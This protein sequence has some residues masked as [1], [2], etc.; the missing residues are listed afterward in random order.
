LPAQPWEE[1]RRNSEE[2]FARKGTDTPPLT[3]HTS[4]T[5]VL[6]QTRL[7]DLLAACG[8]SSSVLGGGSADGGEGGGDGEARPSQFPPGGIDLIRHDLRVRMSSK[9]TGCSEVIQ[10][11]GAMVIQRPTRT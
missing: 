4:R 1:K 10:M 5:E 3:V 7:R 6:W 11:T 8:R 9:K 2:A